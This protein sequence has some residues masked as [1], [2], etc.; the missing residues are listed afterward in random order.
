MP[1]VPITIVGMGRIGRVVARCATKGGCPVS[2]VRRAQGSVAPEGP[3]VIA[4][5]EDDLDAAVLRFSPND[6]RRLVFVQNGLLGQVM[7]RFPGAGR[8]L[9]HF[10]ADGAGNV[11]VIM[12]SVFG[13][14]AGLPIAELLDAGGIPARH[15]SDSQQLRIE[16]I[17]KLLWSTVLSVLAAAHGIPVG[18]VPQVRSEEM[19][20]LAKECILVARQ[21]LPLD[22]APVDDLLASL[23]A[24]ASALPDYPGSRRGQRY[25]NRLL[26]ELGRRLGIAT[27]CNQR[28]LA[29]LGV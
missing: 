10:N 3:I 20:A 5:G 11:R 1:S 16:E 25:R 17:R 12:T 19:A 22:A 26:V 15:E 13:G 27:P 14:A 4:V 9:L 6:G 18:R 8:G 23:P 24:M 7:E 29:M 2:E 21:A 28:V